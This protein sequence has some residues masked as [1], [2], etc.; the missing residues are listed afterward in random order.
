MKSMKQKEVTLT[1]VGIS[2]GYLLNEN[3]NRMTTMLLQ[4]RHEPS[5]M[6][7]KIVCR[8]TGHVGKSKGPRT[9]PV[10]MKPCN[11]P[12]KEERVK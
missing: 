7:G 8:Q 3:K 4:I 6:T 10:G 11:L 2:T 12:S 1:A 9:C 5:W